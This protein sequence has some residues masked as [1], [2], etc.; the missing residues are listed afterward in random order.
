MDDGIKVNCDHKSLGHDQP[1]CENLYSC[2]KR[3]SLSNCTKFSITIVSN[4]ELL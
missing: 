1:E 3:H 2:F 4:Q